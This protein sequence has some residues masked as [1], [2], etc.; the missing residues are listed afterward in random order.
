M[1]HSFMALSTVFQSNRAD[2]KVIDCGAILREPDYF[3]QNFSSIRI[4]IHPQA[5]FH[6][7]TAQIG[8]FLGKIIKLNDCLGML[9]KN[10]TSTMRCIGTENA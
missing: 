7:G 3:R 2:E 5:P 8:F 6:N 1:I 10:V 4:P 9:Q